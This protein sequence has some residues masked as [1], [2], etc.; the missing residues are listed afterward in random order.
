MTDKI[1]LTAVSGRRNSK[2]PTKTMENPWVNGNEEELRMEGNLFDKKT[3]PISRSY[4]LPNYEHARIQHS[5]C[6]VIVYL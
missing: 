2:K 3:H 5:L 1:K 4:K 6:I